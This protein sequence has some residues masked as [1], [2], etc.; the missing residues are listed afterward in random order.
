[1]KSRETT[2]S[3]ID[4]LKKEMSVSNKFEDAIAI[5]RK[6]QQAHVFYKTIRESKWKE[7][8]YEADYVIFDPINGKYR[9]DIMYFNESMFEKFEE[10]KK[11]IEEKQ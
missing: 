4:I 5:S 7:F 10:Y 11:H 9:E 6:F 8:K 2:L 3:S 1:M